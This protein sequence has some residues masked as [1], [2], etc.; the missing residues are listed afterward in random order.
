MSDLLDAVLTPL[1]YLDSALLLAWREI[2]G[3]LM[4]DDGWAWALGFVGMAATIRVLMMPFYLQQ[5]RARRAIQKLEPEIRALKETYGDDRERLAEEQMRLL[6]AAGANPFLSCLP[7]VLLGALLVALFRIID[8]SAKHAPV[9]GSFRRGLVTGTEAESLARAKVL[10]ARIAETFVNTSH[11]QTQ[12]MAAAL[13][14][15][16]CAMHV[17][18][19][20]QDAAQVVTTPVTVSGPIEQRS[21]LLL[22]AV[23]AG[24]AAVSLVLPVGVLIFWAT[25]KVWTVGQQRLLRGYPYADPST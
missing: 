19:Q 16:L 15:V 17:V 5:M 22:P 9:D 21:T 25:S 4:S 10:G 2:F 18:A 23:L 11:S 3:L 1:Y 6:R 24:I 7:L 13:I 8:T 12:V 14:A 20:R